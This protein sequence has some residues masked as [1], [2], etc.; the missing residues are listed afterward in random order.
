VPQPTQR[1]SQLTQGLL[2]VDV[3]LADF[4]DWL[5]AQPGEHPALHGLLAVMVRDYLVA[6]T[7]AGVES[8]ELPPEPPGPRLQAL[9][10]R[11]K[12]TG[13]YQAV[14]GHIVLCW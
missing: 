7:D 12:V 9:R 2:V 4:L 13:P 6:L 10:D 8:G 5:G 14:L 1:V 11:L 3:S